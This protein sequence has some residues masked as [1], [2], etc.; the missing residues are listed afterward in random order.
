M[1]LNAAAFYYDYKDQQLSQVTNLSTTTSNAA[2]STIWGLELEIAALISENFRLDG[3]FA[4]LNAEFDEFCT[5]DGRDLTRPINNTVCPG[6]P[7][8]AGNKLP[9]APDGTGNLAL[10]YI[11]PVGDSGNMDA[12]VEWQYTG[13]QFY[14]VFNR[15][16]IG[17]NG[18]SVFNASVGFVNNDESWSIRGW[19]RNLT[20]KEYFSNL[21][22]S[23]VSGTTT[24]P[25]GFVAPPRT[26][27]ITVGANF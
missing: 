8:L 9:R 16:S 18:V 2:S 12:R 5:N 20:D 14:S 15:D 19:V 22:P 17:Q 6:T 13:D 11:Q 24:V 25:Q 21:F 4:Y 27:G 3:S 10:S 1:Q 7:N 26:Y 23:G